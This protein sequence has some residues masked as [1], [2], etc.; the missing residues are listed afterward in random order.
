VL[1]QGRIVRLKDK[2]TS[3][4]SEEGALLAAYILDYK[5]IH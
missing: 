1:C 4:S 5:F 2:R 3:E